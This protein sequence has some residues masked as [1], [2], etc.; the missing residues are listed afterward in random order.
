MMAADLQDPPE[1][2]GAMLERVAEGRPG[3]L[4]DAARSRP[5]DRRTPGSPR[6]TTGSCG[7]GRHERDAGARGGLLPDRSRRHRRVP[8]CAERNVSVLAL[9]T[10]LGF[11]PGVQSSTTSSPVR[12]GASG[13]TLAEKVK[14]VVDSVTA[15]SGLPDP[16]G[17]PMPV[18][19]ARRWRWRGGGRSRCLPAL[20]VRRSCYWRVVI[21]L[22]GVPAD[23]RWQ[24]VGEYVW[25]G[26]DAARKTPALLRS[27]RSRKEA[28][29]AREPSPP[30]GRQ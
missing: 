22:S 15:F 17:A 29:C 23:R 3:G 20:A 10:W 30:T 21:G 7:R 11:P 14:L 18:R 13:W 16:A 6:S 8:A 9:I 27:K 25:R 12:A 5:G 1:T 28:R 24:Y 4:G 2:I 26:L 19:G